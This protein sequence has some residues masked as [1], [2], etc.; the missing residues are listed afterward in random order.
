MI[1][2]ISKFVYLP[3]WYKGLLLEVLYSFSQV[4]EMIS[5]S[6]ETLAKNEGLTQGHKVRY[7]HKFT[8]YGEY[9]N[10]LQAQPVISII[11]MILLVFKTLSKICNKINLGCKLLK[12]G[13]KYIDYLYS[14][15]MEVAFVDLSFSCFYNLISDYWTSHTRADNL[16]RVMALIFSSALIY[17]YLSI[18]ER[19]IFSP[20]KIKPFEKMI[21]F[22]N[23]KDKKLI[24]KK[25][26][27]NLLNIIF[28][29]KIILL[30]ACITMFQN[31]V[32]FG[33]I[34]MLVL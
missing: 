3:V 4:D 24:K 29:L 13:K 26:T 18:S 25:S 14:L 23:L 7:W 15:V 2:I 9:Q 6:P 28:K 1:E 27:L 19:I 17:H 34:F 30:M 31:L 22:E 20:S 10:V 16:G 8:L 5:V 21:I 33:L 11:L 12:N 32:N